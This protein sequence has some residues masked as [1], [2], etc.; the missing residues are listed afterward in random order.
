MILLIIPLVLI[1][2][3]SVIFVH[4]YYRR[5]FIKYRIK[6]DKSRRYATKYYE[7][8]LNGFYNWACECDEVEVHPFFFWCPV[9]NT[10]AVFYFVFY[11]LTKKI[12]NIR[13]I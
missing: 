1:Y 5:E 8:T 6:R 7:P 2:I 9:V 13:F 11:F 10:I 3:L 12:G 4:L